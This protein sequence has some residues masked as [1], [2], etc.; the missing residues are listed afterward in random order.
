MSQICGAGSGLVAQRRAAP[1]ACCVVSMAGAFPAGPQVAFPSRGWGGEQEAAGA[2]VS[3]C[4]GR[5]AGATCRRGQC[6]PCSRAQ[7]AGRGHLRAP[8]SHGGALFPGPGWGGTPASL[9]PTERSGGCSP[10]AWQEVAGAV[11]K[12]CPLKLRPPSSRGQR[13]GQAPRSDLHGEASR[14][15]GGAQTAAGPQ[16]AD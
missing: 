8:R 4:Q 2:A 15:G 11:E 16:S 6:S 7:K 14:K 12:S 13:R 10:P 5:G 3:P 1:P 9:S